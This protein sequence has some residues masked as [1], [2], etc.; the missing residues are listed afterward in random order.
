MHVRE[1]R[2]DAPQV[3]EDGQE[4]S[5]SRGRQADALVHDAKVGADLALHFIGQAGAAL[6]GLATQRHEAHPRIGL[7]PEGAVRE[8]GLVG[9]E[10]EILADE[11]AGLDQDGL[12][13]EVAE[14]RQTTDGQVDELV[15]LAHL[16][17]VPLHEML[18]G[19]Q[20]RHVA[21]A[22]LIGDPHLVRQLEDIL[23][24]AVVE[25]QQGTQGQEV[26]VR[27]LNFRQVAPGDGF[28]FSQGQQVARTVNREGDVAQQLDVTQAAG[29]RLEV[30]LHEEHARPGLGPALGQF[31]K[32]VAHERR[33]VGPTETFQ[34]THHGLA[35]SS[36][37]EHR[38]L[39]HDRRG[40]D[41]I[42]RQQVRQFRDAP[43]AGTD[44]ELHVPSQGLEL[45]RERRHPR[46]PLTLT[47]H[48]H[49]VQIAEGVQFAPAIAA[50]SKHADLLGPILGRPRPKGRPLG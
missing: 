22:I 28:Q 12:R 8:V 49:D 35:K 34:Q 27:R 42:L 40:S 48:E 50:H 29:V 9:D 5:R 41:K 39:F 46:G 47:D 33:C 31:I 45:G 21:I 13:T 37:R 36:T 16:G 18:D 1:D 25:V 43:Q 17:V 10:T 32:L 14:G 23:L 24:T 38:P 6:L 44:G 26:V 3:A 7:A 4:G 20:A 19:A 30:R 2:T 15:H 11:G